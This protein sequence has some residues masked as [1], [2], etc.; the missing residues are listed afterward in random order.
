[1][2]SRL[3]DEDTARDVQWLIHYDP[4]PPLPRL[5]RGMS[6]L[7]APFYAGKARRLTRLGL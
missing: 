4:D 1:M 7:R 3:T 2:V 5:V 6:G